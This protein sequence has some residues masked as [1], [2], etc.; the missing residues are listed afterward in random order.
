[1]WG[2]QYGLPASF[3]VSGQKNPARTTGDIASQSQLA[4]NGCRQVATGSGRGVGQGAAVTGWQAN[5]R[6]L[7]LRGDISGPTQWIFMFRHAK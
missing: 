2:E 1:M 7:T 4:A 3:C 5:W 6:P